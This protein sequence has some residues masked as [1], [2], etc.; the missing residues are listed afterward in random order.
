MQCNSIAQQKAV[1]TTV[2]LPS[3]H[4]QTVSGGL[5]ADYQENQHLQE[6][7]SQLIDQPAHPFWMNKTQGAPIQDHYV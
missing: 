7:S 3:K 4:G 1:S 2:T 6:T 5:S